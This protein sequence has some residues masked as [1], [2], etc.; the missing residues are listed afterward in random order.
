MMDDIFSKKGFTDDEEEKNTKITDLIKPKKTLP[1]ADI[2]KK[3]IEQLNNELHKPKTAVTAKQEL[4]KE[5]V[6]TKRIPRT[7][8]NEEIVEYYRE[9][10]LKR[11]AFRHWRRFTAMKEERELRV[12]TKNLY[13]I[14]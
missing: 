11:K 13:L 3:K 6:K 10:T 7:R 8:Q 5:E 12:E 2:I 9:N 14:L 4:V 1:Q